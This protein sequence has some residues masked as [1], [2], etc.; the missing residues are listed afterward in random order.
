[1]S[2][3]SATSSRTLFSLAFLDSRPINKS[4]GVAQRILQICLDK[5]H[6]VIP[7]LESIS[8]TIRS[9]LPDVN[10]SSIFHRLFYQE[11][12]NLLIEEIELSSNEILAA[13]HQPL[14]MQN[15]KAEQAVGELIKGKGLKANQAHSDQLC[16][17][18][19]GRS[20]R[21]AFQFWHDS[22]YANFK[23]KNA[24][25]KVLHR[26]NGKKANSDEFIVFCR[27]LL[28]LYGE[29]E[30]RN[31]ANLMT[32][33]LAV[34]L[35]NLVDQENKN[36]VYSLCDWEWEVCKDK[37]NKFQIE[38][39]FFY[40]TWALHTNLYCSTII[41]SD[42]ICRR[43]SIDQDQLKLDW[44]NLKSSSLKVEVWDFHSN[45]ALDTKEYVFV[46]EEES[47]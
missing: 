3:S 38:L 4:L 1:M 18:R 5:A 45:S 6:S 37:N 32:R 47:I 35:I 30:F 39:E 15:R 2:V 41:G 42:S 13:M 17:N 21:F 24:E 27:Q 12:S 36:K 10:V 9:T 25:G 44:G 43:V 14:W 23:V 16:F 11:P 46:D 19:D 7:P 29:T 28:Q 22:R 26:Y 33:T 8:V 40:S 20:I 31:L 34:D